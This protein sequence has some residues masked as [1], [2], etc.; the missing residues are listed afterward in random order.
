MIPVYIILI[1]LIKNALFLK[2]L[3]ASPKELYYFYNHIRSLTSSV[4]NAALFWEAQSKCQDN[5]PGLWHWPMLS[6][7]HVTLS[8]FHCVSVQGGAGT[9]WEQRLCIRH[10]ASAFKWR[11]CH[12][13]DPW[14]AHA[15]TNIMPWGRLLVVV[16]NQSRQMA[17]CVCVLY[18]QWGRWVLAAFNRLAILPSSTNTRQAHTHKTWLECGDIHTEIHAYV[19]S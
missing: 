6:V 8:C 17:D 3:L 18:A 2:L 13:L 14:N 19:H 1:T 7:K 10:S 11:A 15:G 16:D 12:A 5:R 4:D 9:G